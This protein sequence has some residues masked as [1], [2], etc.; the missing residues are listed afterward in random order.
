MGRDA[1]PRNI[2]STGDTAG[3][4]DFFGDKHPNREPQILQD[5]TSVRWPHGWNDI[6]AFAWR[7]LHHLLRPDLDDETHRWE[8]RG[9]G[10]VV[11]IYGLHGR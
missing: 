7:K 1:R 8:D 9:N 3:Y 4:A 6:D 2:S 10:H 11:H 5:G